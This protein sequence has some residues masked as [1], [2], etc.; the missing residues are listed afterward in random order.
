MT[1]KAKKIVLDKGRCPCREKLPC[2]RPEHCNHCMR[3]GMEGHAGGSDYD[4]GLP[5]VAPD[6]KANP[7]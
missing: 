6:C 2:C 7:K 4:P 5:C 1:A 3:F